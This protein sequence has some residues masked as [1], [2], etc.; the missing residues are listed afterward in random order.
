MRPDTTRVEG[1]D[2]PCRPGAAAAERCYT[3]RSN[4]R[5]PMEPPI[6]T[7][8]G[9]DARETDVAVDTVRFRPHEIAGGQ[10][11]QL[12][13]VAGQPS[14]VA[15][16]C[17]DHVATARELSQLTLPVAAPYLED[18]EAWRRARR[19]EEAVLLPLVRTILPADGS[20]GAGSLNRAELMTEAVAAGEDLGLDAIESARDRLVDRGHLEVRHHDPGTVV[21]LTAPGLERFHSLSD[22][23]VLL[24]DDLRDVLDR[25]YHTN[26]ATLE[27]S[28]RSREALRRETGF[29]AARLDIAVWYLAGRH[30]LETT[31]G[32]DGTWWGAVT[33]TEAG[34]RFSDVSAVLDLEAATGR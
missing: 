11:L 24:P 33:I 32:R 17:E 19:A 34:R 31:P 27:D 16:F 28:T 29:D 4:L 5:Q 7:V 9:A 30:L 10:P 6:C 23:A 14:N 15:W 21:E 18:A 12:G 2:G 26:R 22:H 25:C 20:T 3:P 8:C 13:P 1:F